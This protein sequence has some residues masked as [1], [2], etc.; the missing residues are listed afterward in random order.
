MLCGYVPGW[1]APSYWRGASF[2]GRLI[3]L[4][5]PGMPA[6]PHSELRGLVRACGAQ[7]CNHDAFLHSQLNIFQDGRLAETQHQVNSGHDSRPVHRS[8]NVERGWRFWGTL[9]PGV[10]SNTSHPTHRARVCRQRGRRP[11]CLRR[12]ERRCVSRSPNCY[13]LKVMRR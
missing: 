13:E 12:W 3:R 7:Q 6:V 4:P 11:V 2:A 8:R 10:A 1:E 5:V 9:P